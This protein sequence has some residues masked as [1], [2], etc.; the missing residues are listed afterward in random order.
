MLLGAHGVRL[1]WGPDLLL[2]LLLLQDPLLQ[3]LLDVGGAVCAQPRLPHLA[4]LS[5]LGRHLAHGAALDGEVLLH[6]LLLHG[7]G[8]ASRSLRLLEL[9]V[10]CHA[11]GHASAALLPLLLLLLLRLLAEAGG[12]GGGGSGG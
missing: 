7:W 4:E 3:G 9:A 10:P 8:V 2:H 1:A 6:P 12:S 5:H 11:P